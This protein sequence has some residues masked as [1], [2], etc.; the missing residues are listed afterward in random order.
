MV[1]QSQTGTGKTAA[2]SLPILDQI[3][4]DQKAVQALILTPTRELAVQALRSAASLA[5]RGYEFWQSTEVKQLTAK[6]YSSNA[7]FIL[8]LERRDG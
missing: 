4:P 5:T 1:G 8:W 7:V 6:F 2:F 3:D